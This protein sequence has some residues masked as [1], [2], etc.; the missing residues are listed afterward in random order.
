VAF[1]IDEN[2]VA[3]QVEISGSGACSGLL[4]DTIG[5]SSGSLD[6]TLTPMMS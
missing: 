5:I 4:V 3:M 6:L 1:A 2:G